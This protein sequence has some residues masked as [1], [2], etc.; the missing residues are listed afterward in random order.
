EYTLVQ[1]AR[2]Q[3]G[4]GAPG[5]QR[6]AWRH[7]SHASIAEGALISTPELRA[8]KKYLAAC[9]LD[10]EALQVT[11]LPAGAPNPM[12]EMAFVFDT[13]SAVETSKIALIQRASWVWTSPAC[14]P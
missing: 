8:L 7:L 14:L 12:G 4:R 1:S 2:G 5:R 11:P 3:M 10:A 9:F 13:K 6:T